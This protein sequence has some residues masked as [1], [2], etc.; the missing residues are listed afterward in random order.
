LAYG[1]GGAGHRDGEKSIQYNILKREVDSNAPA[2]RWHAQKVKETS[3]ASAMRA[4]NARVWTP[5][6]LLHR[7]YTKLSTN[8]AIGLLAACS[9][10]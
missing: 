3:I 8:A 1:P 2:L 4:S 10:E 6:N 7:L 5:P 9:S